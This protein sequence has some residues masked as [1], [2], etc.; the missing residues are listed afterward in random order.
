VVGIRGSRPTRNRATISATLHRLPPTETAIDNI[1]LENID[2]K[3]LVSEE[4]LLSPTERALRLPVLPPL[5]LIMH[6]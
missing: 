2:E 3:R 4:V 6:Y 1:V 5:P